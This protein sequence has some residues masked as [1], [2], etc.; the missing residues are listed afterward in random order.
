MYSEDDLEF[1]R[2]LVEA[3]HR[4][5]PEGLGLPAG[6]VPLSAV[7]ALAR[8]S[9]QAGPFFPADARPDALGDGA[10]IE[11]LSARR[12]RV[13]ERF[14]VGQMRFSELSSRSF[15]SL[16]GAVIRY[17]GHYGALLRYHGIRIARWS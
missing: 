16:R 14:E 2:R 15:L 13:H 1:A 8:T 17:L 3:I 11:R 4:G 6:R 5:A 10:V 12:Y 7:V 9:L